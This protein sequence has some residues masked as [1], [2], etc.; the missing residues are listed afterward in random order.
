MNPGVIDS[1]VKIVTNGLVL[2][3]D[4]AQLRSYSGSGTTW[5]DLSGNNNATTLNNTPT[6]NNGNGGYFTFTNTATATA[7][8]S[9]TLDCVNNCTLDM[10]IQFPENF[11]ASNYNSI[12]DKNQSNNNTN[13]LLSSFKGDG[14]IAFAFTPNGTPDNYRFLY[15]SN[16]NF[17]TL[18]WTHL[19]CRITQNGSNSDMAMFKNGSSVGT[20]DNQVGN[21]VANTGN[22]LAGANANMAIIRIYNTALTSTQIGQNY[23]AEKSRFGL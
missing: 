17:T 3:L 10:W 21:C 15:V 8:D 13:Y 4:A 19:V 20:L 5:T 22:L 7:N 1:G 18:T 11:G 23:N 2:Y 14:L 12:V 6:F 9:S 16:S